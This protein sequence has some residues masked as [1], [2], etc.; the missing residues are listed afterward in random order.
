MGTLYQDIFVGMGAPRDRV[1]VLDIRTPVDARQAKAVE[2]LKDA[3]AVYF[4]GGDQERLSD[5]LSDTELMESIRL[6]CRSGSLVV[7]G[8]SA[9]ASALGHH[10][11]SRGYSGESPTP[12]IVTVKTGLGL[13]PNVIVD[14]HFHQRNRLVRLITAVAYHP[15]CIGMGIDENT[16]AIIRADQTLTVIGVG[17]VTLVDGSHMTSTV[18]RTPEDDLFNLSDARVHFLGTGSRFDLARMKPL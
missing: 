4:T 11:I 12:A 14:Q 7:G 3:T 10:M 15:H 17:S 16:A 8:T 2:A 6:R 13:L 18:E 5:V 1:S 9:G